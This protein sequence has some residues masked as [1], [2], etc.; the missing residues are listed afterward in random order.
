MSAGPAECGAFFLVGPTAVG[1]TG[2]AQWIAEREGYTV[3]SADS[4]LVYRGMDI[5]TA[6]PTPAERGRVP[7]LGLDLTTP[8]RSFSVWD[9]CAAVRGELVRLVEEGRQVLVVGGTGLYMKGLT[10]GLHR[11]PPP[12]RDLRERW[13]RTARDEGVAV[14]QDALR[15]AA[16]RLYDALPDKTNARRLVRGLELAEAGVLD[17]PRTWGERHAYAPLAGLSMPDE[18]LHSRIELRIE[19]MYRDGLEEEA[20]DLLASY[21]TLSATAGRAIGYAETID[22]LAGRCTREQAMA[23]TAGRTR[24]LAKRQRTWFRHQARVA[25]IDIAGDTDTAAAAQR[26]LAHWRRH[27]PTP[28][29]SVKE[30]Q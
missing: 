29:A 10:H 11:G 5:G 9:Y 19:E 6:K 17:P 14:L 22:V 2:V 28:I 26:V 24:R 1:K 27:G 15:D 13:V 18:M 12:D 8:D 30:A 23:A 21:G 7:Y 4:M 3:V 20:R 16:P 25:W